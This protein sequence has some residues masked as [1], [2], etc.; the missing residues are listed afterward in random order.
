MT[1]VVRGFIVFGVRAA[2]RWLNRAP[3]AIKVVE[4]TPAV[5]IAARVIPRVLSPQH[6]TARR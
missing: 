5:A 2:L 1:K 4:L 3:L 6:D